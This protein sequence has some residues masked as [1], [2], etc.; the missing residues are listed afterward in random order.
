MKKNLIPIVFLVVMVF[1]MVG[2]ASAAS[3]TTGVSIQKTTQT[4]LIDSGFNK[5]YWGERGGI[6]SYS[7]KTY[8]TSN[9][10]LVNIHYKTINNSWYGSYYI[11]KDSKNKLKIV[12]TSPEVKLYS[13]HPSVTSYA[14][15]S[16]TP[17]QFYWKTVKSQVKSDGY[18]FV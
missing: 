6:F 15:T 1:L 11:T 18:F 14:K 17:L 3:N 2:A 16:L 8:K 7:W 5:F 9:G 10:I 13:G 12:E 4:S